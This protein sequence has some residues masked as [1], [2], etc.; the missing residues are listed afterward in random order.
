MKAFHFDRTMQYKAGDVIDLNQLND[1]QP[2]ALGEIVSERYPE[3]MS[4]QGSV[5]YASQG[6]ELDE[7][8]VRLMHIENVFEYERRLHF[9]HRTSRF[10]SVFASRELS[11]V[12]IWG[13]ELDF[14]F[15]KRLWEIEF[16]PSNYI[17]LDAA[18]LIFDYKNP[19]FLTAA[20]YAQ[21]YWS[22][23]FSNS[24]KPELL[25]KPP[26]RFIREVQL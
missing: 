10:Q 25:I 6:N 7:K 14:P 22:G 17:E 9:P 8:K 21:K 16:D 11:V 24:P 12:K 26:I 3:G 18:W 23:E 13:D 19:S 1:I 5:Y 15:G 20:Y 2:P 4:R